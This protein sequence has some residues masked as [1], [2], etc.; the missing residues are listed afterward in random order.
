MNELNDPNE[1]SEV[2]LND[3]MPEDMEVLFLG[4]LRRGPTWTPEVTPEI[5]ALQEAKAV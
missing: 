4:L 3:G 1:P 2:V 5:E